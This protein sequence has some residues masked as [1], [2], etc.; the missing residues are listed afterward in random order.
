MGQVNNLN[1]SQV[2]AL[3]QRVKRNE[4]APALVDA[5]FD[6]DELPTTTQAPNLYVDDDGVVYRCI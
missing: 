5:A 4:T 6:I 1:R 2:P 3:Y